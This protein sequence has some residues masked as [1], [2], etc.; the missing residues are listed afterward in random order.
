MILSVA[1]RAALRQICCTEQLPRKH[2]ILS[3]AARAALRLRGVLLWTAYTVILSV[4]ARAALRRNIPQ[5]EYFFHRDSFRCCESG[6]ETQL[7]LHFSPSIEILSV[8]ARA[9]LRQLGSNA[10]FETQGDSFRCCESGIETISFNK[11]HINILDSFRCC[12]SGIETLNFA[13]LVYARITILSFAARVALRQFIR[14]SIQVFTVDSFLCCESGIETY[15][16]RCTWL[17]QRRFFPLLRE[18]H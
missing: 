4:A 13:E 14:I 10:H 16:Y 7:H 9:A 17:I 15:L 2:L 8:A 1:A 11:M 18:W 5:I 12:E 6:I 3:V